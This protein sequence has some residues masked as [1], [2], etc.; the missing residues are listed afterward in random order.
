MSLE[1]IGPSDKSPPK[2]DEL[3]GYIKQSRQEKILA[4]VRLFLLTVVLQTDAVHIRDAYED[5]MASGRKRIL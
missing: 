3:E 1:S 5:T 2:S 4:N